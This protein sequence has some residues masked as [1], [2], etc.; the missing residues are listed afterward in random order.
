MSNTPWIDAHVHLFPESDSDKE[1]PR[2]HFFHNRVNT[3][4]TYRAANGDERSEGVV[5]V[6]F[7]QAPDASHVV[8]ALDGLSP[9]C[10]PHFRGVIKADV[11]DPRTFAWALRNDIAGVR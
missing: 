5:I 9:K 1:W 10:K 8:Q 2:L 3:P 7:S 6:H 4:A 11:K